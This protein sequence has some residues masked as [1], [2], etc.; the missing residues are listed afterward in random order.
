MGVEDT[1]VID[2]IGLDKVTDEAVLTIVDGNKWDGAEHLFALQE[3]LNAYLRFVESGEILDSYP[4]A[5]GKAVRIEVVFKSHPDPAGIAFLEKA[6]SAIR[7]ASLAF[8]WR[9]TG[10][11]A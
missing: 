10:Y 3:K 9:V 11:A 7:G 5:T 8:S 1:D 6:G 2:A 4:N